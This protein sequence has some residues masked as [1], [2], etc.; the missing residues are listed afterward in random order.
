MR[1]RVTFIVGFAAGFIAGT[2]AG[3]ERYE[4]IVRLAHRVADNP[5]VQQAAGA[6]QAQAS[7][8]TVTAR[9]KVSERLHD[10]IP[11]LRADRNGTGDGA[12]VNAQAS[13]DATRTRH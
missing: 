1:Y 7:T 11:W 10:R 6:I 8:F 2:R 12:F 5:A 4:Q 9:N 13:H 3:R